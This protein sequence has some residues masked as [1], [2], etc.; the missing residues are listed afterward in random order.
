[1]K[2]G[3]RTPSLKKSFKARTTG[4]AKRAI[5][6]AIIPGYGKK[7]MGWIKNP[8]KAAYNAVYH[9]TTIGV[10]SLIATPKKSRKKSN[11]SSKSTYTRNK[12]QK[13]YTSS[14][15]SQ[16]SNKLCFGILLIITGIIQLIFSP[17]LGAFGIIIGTFLIYL[18]RKD[19]KES[20]KLS[21]TP[22]SEIDENKE[23]TYIVDRHYQL[24]DSQ[25]QQ[26]RDKNFDLAEIVCKEDIELYPKF[27]KAYPISEVKKGIPKDSVEMPLYPAFLMLTKIYEHQGKFDDAISICEKAL[28]YGLD[29]GTKGGYSGRETRLQRKK[30]NI[31]KSLETTSDEN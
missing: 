22:D 28:Q 19:S 2:F 15:Q 17:V 6:K 18:D 9:R 8:K 14:N 5:K 25:N 31:E 26:Y 10:S 1:M 27:L 7:G 13:S 11:Y 16:V 23:Y 24:L 3:V 21:T 4:R 30:E 20:S 29:D 12:G